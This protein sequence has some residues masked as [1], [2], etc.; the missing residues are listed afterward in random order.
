MINPLLQ[1]VAHVNIFIF[2]TSSWTN[3]GL[4]LGQ[5]HFSYKLNQALS[6]NAV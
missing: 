4:V 3:E 5:L 1:T 6:S 2:I